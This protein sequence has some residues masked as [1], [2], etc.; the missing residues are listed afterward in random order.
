MVADYI[1]CNCTLLAFGPKRFVAN[2]LVANESIEH[3]WPATCHLC[4]CRGED[5]TVFFAI[6]RTAHECNHNHYIIP[7]SKSVT[8]PLTAPLQCQC[9]LRIALHCAF[10]DIEL[11]PNLFC[12]TPPR[13]L[14]ASNGWS[15]QALCVPRI[16]HQHHQPENAGWKLKVSMQFQ[17]KHLISYEAPTF[18][19]L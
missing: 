9:T 18:T 16:F 11:W 8:I 17:M 6:M 3:S 7:Q 15:L 4:L 19:L 2:F 12:I 10:L 13:R 14:E 5:R 1:V